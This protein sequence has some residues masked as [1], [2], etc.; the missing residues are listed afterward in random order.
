MTGAEM[1]R[2]SRTIAKYLPTLRGRV[3]L[4]ELRALLLEHEVDDPTARLAVLADRRAGQLLATEERRELGEVELLVLLHLDVAEGHEVEAPGLADE[5]ADRH[6]GPRRPGSSTT[7][8][9]VPCVVIER[10]GDA[11]RVH[12]PLDD[13]A[14]DLEVLGPR[15]LVADLLRLVLHAEA[16]LEVQPELR[17][18]RS[19]AVGRL[20][21]RAR[22]GRERSR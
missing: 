16:A 10:L 6:S 11:G 22:G 21:C 14:D 1:T 18:D 3:L 20:R 5:P 9:S 15:N 8:R 12:P 4:E 2:E 7:I 13:V 19:L 17:L